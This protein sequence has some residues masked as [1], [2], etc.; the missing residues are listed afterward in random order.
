MSA[1]KLRAAVPCTGADARTLL[2][3]AGHVIYKM[4][5]MRATHLRAAVPCAGTDA[6]TLLGAASRDLQNAAHAQYTPESRSPPRR[7]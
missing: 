4:L 7:S 2:G 5:R 3:A 6:V 1:T